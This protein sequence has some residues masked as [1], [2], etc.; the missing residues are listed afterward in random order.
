MSRSGQSLIES[1]IVMGIMCFVFL[2]VFQL[3]QLFAAREFL[4]YS[5]ARGVRA[6]AVGFNN[7]MVW[8]TMRVGV[9]PNAGVMISPE[10]EHPPTD[11]GTGTPA[12]LWSAWQRAMRETPPSAQGAVEQSRIPL[13]LG[14]QWRGQLPPIL[15][16][17]DWDTVSTPDP[18][19]ELSGMLS[20]TVSQDYPLR[21]PMHTAF[22]AGD[23]IELKGEARMENHHSLYLTDA[24][25]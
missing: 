6:K 23:S 13:Y 3:S 14:A 20:V 21:V 1:C 15:D 17:A 19:E 11:W 24:E 16:Y 2:G 5:A 7:F 12:A 9:I 18:T 8:K 22:Y 4:S 25:L 10:F